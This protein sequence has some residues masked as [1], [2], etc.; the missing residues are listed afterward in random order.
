MSTPEDANYSPFPLQAAG[1]VITSIHTDDSSNSDGAS[2]SVPG[3]TGYII[4]RE[5]GSGSSGITYL[6]SKTG[7]EAHV[8]L[9]VHHASPGQGSTS[10]RT[11]RELDTLAQ[12]RAPC[13]PRLL[14]Y[15]TTDLSFYIATEFIEGSPLNR[16]Y[17]N[18]A[19]VNARE[20]R[21]RIT[22]LE[23]IAR[24]AH[25]LHE[26]GVI[27]RDL[28]PSN[29]IVSLD[30][31]PFII[32]LGIALIDSPDLHQT[33]TVDGTPIGT[34]AFMAPEQARGKHAEIS[35]R[36]DIYSL[37]AIGYWLC[38]GQTPH[39]LTGVTLH[40]AI[41][42]VGSEP[43]RQPRSISAQLPKQLAAVLAKACAQMRDDRY[44][45]SDE[46]AAD[47][48][49]WLTG[50]AVEATT[51]GFWCRCTRWVGQHPIVTTSIACLS[52]AGLVIAS[53]FMSLWWL[54]QRPFQIIIDQEQ[55]RWARMIS[56]SGDT[57]YTWES[58]KNDGIQFAQI[59]DRPIELGGGRVIVTNVYGSSQGDAQLDG[60]LCVWDAND[61]TELLWATK[62]TAPYIIAPAG[63]DRPTDRYPVGAMLIADIFPERPGL[64]IVVCHIHTYDPTAIRVYDLAGNIL[65]ETWRW[66]SADSIYWLED[67]GYLIFQGCD[68]TAPW[69]ELGYPEIKYRWPVAFFAIKPILGQ[70]LGWINGPAASP[71]A[72]PVWQRYLLPP[73][74]MDY[75]AAVKFTSSVLENSSAIDRFGITLTLREGRGSLIFTLDRHGNVVGEPVVTDDYRRFPDNPTPTW[76]YF[77]DSIP[78][79][80]IDH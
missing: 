4:D 68:N 36:S 58:S 26:H 30:G 13:V 7:S 51:P 19:P 79:A 1:K 28:K 39:D 41:L 16:L 52:I 59:V 15:G 64:E 70:K 40:E 69:S 10:T 49:R 35:T 38:T 75:L 34:P 71:D 42:R 74:A 33:L 50:Q 9:K 8:A 17:E 24:A 47:L 14:D 29:I 2:L 67:P 55:G 45:S 61:P 66:G 77:A 78:P 22:L 12:L 57:L 48:H 11:W 31:N 5:L 73:V 20:L 65:F 76:F 46:F 72:D 3:I 27:H 32:D 25:T 53:T 80:T 56:V 63:L 54:N 37:G 62:P 18:A 23:H 43:P 44:S 6:A 21:E 60:Q